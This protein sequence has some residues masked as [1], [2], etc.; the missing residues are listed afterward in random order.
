M[1]SLMTNVSVLALFWLSSFAAMQIVQRAG[2]HWAVVDGTLV[3]MTSLALAFSVRLR[4]RVAAMLLAS[5][6]AMEVAELAIHL[7]YGIRSAQGAPSHFA[8]LGAAMIAVVLATAF[9][10]APRASAPAAS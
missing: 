1:K 3:V 5:F 10:R 6:V 9:A 8:T 7:T 4:A 2:M